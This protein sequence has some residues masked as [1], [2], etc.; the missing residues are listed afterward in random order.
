MVDSQ[1]PAVNLDSR[2]REIFPRTLEKIERDALTPVL[3][4]F[5]ERWGAEMQ[6]LENFRFFPMF[7]KQGHQAEAIVQMADYEYL[8]AWVETID[9]GPWHSGVNPSWQWLP[10]VSGADE[11]GKDRGVYALW[12]NAQTQQR[13][14]KCLTPREA[15]LLWMITEE[16]TLTPDL[17]KAYQREIDSFQKQG[18]IALDFAAI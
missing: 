1:V 10:L 18:L 15:E 5:S 17:R 11:L 14:E 2:L 7:L 9:L 4:L 3:Q 13:E 12:K 8:C 6:E 16:V